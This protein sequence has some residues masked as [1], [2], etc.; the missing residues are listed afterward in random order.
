MNGELPVAVEQEWLSGWLD[1]RKFAMI[2]STSMFIAVS[3]T[4]VTQNTFKACD[5][6]LNLRNQVTMCTNGVSEHDGITMRQR[7]QHCLQIISNFDVV[8]PTYDVTTHSIGSQIFGQGVLQLPEHDNL[9]R[10]TSQVQTARPMKATY[11]TLQRRVSLLVH[12]LLTS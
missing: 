7:N 5:T 6:E 10:D 8:T 2:R 3:C 11:V 4:N 1:S 9:S 12:D